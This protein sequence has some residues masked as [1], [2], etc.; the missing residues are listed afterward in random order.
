MGLGGLKLQPCG[1]GMGLNHPLGHWGA[2]DGG[3]H[4]REGCDLTHISEQALA[5]VW[6]VSVGGPPRSGP[7]C[8]PQAPME[9]WASQASLGHLGG[10]S[11]WPCHLQTQD[12]SLAFAFKA[13]PQP[14]LVIKSLSGPPTASSLWVIMVSPLCA[15]TRRRPAFLGCQAARTAVG[16]DPHPRISLSI[17]ALGLGRSSG[18]LFSPPLHHQPPDGTLIQCRGILLLST[19]LLY[20]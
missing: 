3:D 13:R 16:A 10:P 14:V 5:Q 2:A 9:L 1:L 8:H 19:F 11:W 6:E 12:R 18:S 17:P 4:A 15:L 7:T 20:Y